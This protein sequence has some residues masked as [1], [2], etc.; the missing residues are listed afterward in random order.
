MSQTF[1]LKL[2]TNRVQLALQLYC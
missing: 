1:S 2:M